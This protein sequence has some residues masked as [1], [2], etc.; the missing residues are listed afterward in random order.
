VLLSDIS[1]VISCWVLAGETNEFYTSS[2]DLFGIAV[3]LTEI[4]FEVLSVDGLGFIKKENTCVLFY[5][6]DQITSGTAAEIWN[7]SEA[8][9]ERSI[10]DSLSR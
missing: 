5:N 4:G 8:L 1:N 9:Q 3:C 10:D 7:P 2:S 6:P